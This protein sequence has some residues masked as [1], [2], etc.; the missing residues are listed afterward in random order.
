MGVGSAGCRPV[1]RCLA[2]LSRM[3]VRCCPDVVQLNPLGDFQMHG[4]HDTAR[5][6]LTET[7]GRLG[8]A[9]ASVSRASASDWCCVLLAC[10]RGIAAARRLRDNSKA[11]PL[12]AELL[13]VSNESRT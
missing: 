8:A 7:G 5:D 10:G 12:S 3:G 6:A 4:V 9:V 2:Q 11:L 13:L 1:L